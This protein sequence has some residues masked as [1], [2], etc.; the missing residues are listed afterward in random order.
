MQTS[1]AWRNFS[2]EERRRVPDL[3]FAEKCKLYKD[4]FVYYLIFYANSNRM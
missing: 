2:L 4:I 1:A 3:L